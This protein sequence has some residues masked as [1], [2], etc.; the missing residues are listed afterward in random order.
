MAPSPAARPYRR[1]SR[2]QEALWEFGKKTKQ[3]QNLGKIKGDKYQSLHQTFP[4]SLL[5]NPITLTKMNVL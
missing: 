4:L 2:R 5:L 1:K 3:D